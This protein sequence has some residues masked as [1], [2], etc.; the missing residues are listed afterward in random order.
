MMTKHVKLAYYNM[1]L[2]TNNDLTVDDKIKAYLHMHGITE[3]VTIPEQEK[4]MVLMLLSETDID[5]V[6]V[7]NGD[8]IIE[9]SK[10]NDE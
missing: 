5:T 9:S 3:D 4:E 2:I 10:E 8:L 7:E 1:N 6:Y